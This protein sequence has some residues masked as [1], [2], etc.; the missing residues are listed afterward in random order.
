[1]ASGKVAKKAVQYQDSPKGKSRCDNC[2]QW[3][4]PA[5]CKLVDG[6]ISPAGWCM[7]YA[8]VPKA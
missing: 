6:P 3:Q 8:P 2:R 7:I 5:A 4:A 1:M